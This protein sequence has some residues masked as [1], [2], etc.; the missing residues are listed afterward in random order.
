MFKLNDHSIPQ[1]NLWIIA[2]NLMQKLS[3]E[4]QRMH[5]KGIVVYIYHTCIC[6]LR[7]LHIPELLKMFTMWEVDQWKKTTGSVLRAV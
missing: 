1:T 5:I 2:V 3:Y 4:T 7:L 6:L